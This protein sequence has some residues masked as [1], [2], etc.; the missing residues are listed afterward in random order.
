[1]GFETFFGDQLFLFVYDDGRQSKQ[2]AFYKLSFFHKPSLSVDRFFCFKVTR[3]GT[4]LYALG[5][6]NGLS[7]RIPA[8]IPTKAGTPM[9]LLHELFNN[10]CILGM[11]L[12]TFHLFTT[13]NKGFISPSASLDRKLYFSANMG[14]LGIILMLSTIH[15]NGTIMDLRQIPVVIS[16]IYGGVLPSILVS[17]IIA[18]G[19]ILL[20]PVDEGTILA[21]VIMVLLGI[22]CGALSKTRLQTGGKWIAMIGTHLLMVTVGYF[23]IIQDKTKLSAINIYY[24]SVS[25][26]GAAVI[27]FLM[28]HLRKSKELAQ[29]VE[30]NAVTDFLLQTSLDRFSHELFGVVKVSEMERR[31]VME[32]KEVMNATCVSLIEADRNRGLIIKTGEGHAPNRLLE[33]IGKLNP[34]LLQVCEIIDMPNGC[35]IKITEI[36]EKSYL[37][38]IGEK[39]PKATS[40]RVWLNTI[41]RYASVLYDNFRV[42][43]DLTKEI[44]QTMAAHQTAPSWLLRLLFHLSENERKSL[45]QDL[46]DGALQEQI[47]WYR[48]ME[49]L[50]TDHTVP[51]QLRKQLQPIVEGL[52]DVVYQ[53][54]MT[55]N[56]LRPPMLKEFGLVSSL[57]AL[58]ELTQMRANYFIDFEAS[59]FHHTPNDETLI[60]L[61]RI[62]QELLANAAKH[63]NATRVSVTLMSNMDRI[64]LTYEDNGVG[65]AC[66][67]MKDSFDN[68]GIYGIKERVRSMDGHIE[69][70]SQTDEGLA[71]FISIPAALDEV[72]HSAG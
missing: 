49:L 25:V 37:L 12:V 33:D 16:A 70:H 58:F 36:R 29:T 8:S 66:N 17:L 2:R 30:E 10:L 68:M 38:C 31:L 20:F 45:S 57:G 35:L 72:T 48:Q 7:K 24:W 32:V 51:E 40:K 23:L 14:L 67:A 4:L 27:Y 19:R 60:S 42:I 22:L 47:V 5:F 1:V 28:E 26:I 61:Y 9:K 52:L 34:T 44:E 39:T 6:R 46:H 11:V 54:R 62:V 56:E 69:F 65:L 18:A 55:C 41:T 63:S 15:F 59:K 50:S 13:K 43:E 3:C 53:I 64:Q 21:A 71:I